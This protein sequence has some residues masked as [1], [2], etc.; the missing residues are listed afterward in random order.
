MR[1]S[2][3]LVL[4]LP[5]ALG[6]CEDKKQK[7]VKL[8][9]QCH[10]FCKRKSQ[11]HE[12]CQAFCKKAEVKDCD[13]VYC[14]TPLERFDECDACCDKKGNAEEFLL[15]MCLGEADMSDRV[16][17]EKS[18]DIWKKLV[19]DRVS[20]EK[21]AKD[22]RAA[23]DHLAAAAQKGWHVSFEES[24]D[25]K[26]V[27]VVLVKKAAAAPAGAKEG[28]LPDLIFRCGGGAIEAYV[29]VATQIGG[30]AKKTKIALH[31]DGKKVTEKMAKAETNDTLIFGN[32]K[33]ALAK[34]LRAKKLGVAFPAKAGGNARV[35]FDLDGL[36]PSLEPHAGEC[37][38]K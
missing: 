1:L 30:S 26:V 14:T 32:A 24:G 15:G 19:N 13:T 4:L 10:E 34:M 38:I 7:V 22:N 5:L 36:E 27:A 9:E 28:V 21:K 8:R 18:W 16:L 17:P 25:G 33:K 3:V 37:G 23:A 29:H 6:G 20:K 35:D 31:Y 11:V 2:V 12:L